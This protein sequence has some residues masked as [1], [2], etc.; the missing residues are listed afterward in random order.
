MKFSP[1]FKETYQRALDLA[2]RRNEGDADEEHLLIALMTD[3]SVKGLLNTKRIDPEEIIGGVRLNFTEQSP[4]PQQPRRSR[5]TTYGFDQIIEKATAIAVSESHNAIESGFVLSA[6]LSSGKPSLRAL[7]LSRRINA[8]AVVNWNRLITGNAPLSSTD[9]IQYAIEQA[10]ISAPSF[11]AHH[12]RLRYQQSKADKRLAERKA[13]AK[14]RAH[15]L[16]DLCARRGNEQ[17]EL[18]KLV[19]RY[20]AALSTLRRDSGAY[21][22]FIGGLEIERFVR[23]KG[24]S[25]ADSEDSPPLTTDIKQAVEFLI[26]A[27]AGLIVLFPD[28]QQISREYDQFRELA[29]SVGELQT[30]VLSPI[31]DKLLTTTAIFD[32]ATQNITSKIK[33]METEERLI[34]ALPSKGTISAMHAWLRG[35]LTSM[36]SYLIA[37]IKKVP[38]IAVGQVTKSAV[39]KSIDKS[40]QLFL[41]IT[42]FLEKGRV[43]LHSLS[44]MLPS[45]FGWLR[46]LLTH[47][48]LG[49]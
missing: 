15:D 11:S 42:A 24:D 44:D 33:E 41:A 35:I 17:P 22:L 43:V 34:R 47:L 23:W 5:I 9:E 49:G 13:V 10:A 27:H 14:E 45:A 19:E 20:V 32:E 28:I 12:G 2:K 16:H 48:G 25:V 21:K 8:A 1:S 7:L 6:L 4:Y 31:F 40:D 29:R 30:Q 46:S 36:G 38:E 26:V 37:V 18:N 39:A 3:P